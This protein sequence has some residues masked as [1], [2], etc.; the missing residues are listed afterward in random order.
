MPTDTEYVRFTISL[1][2][3]T[4]QSSAIHKLGRPITP[5]F[6]G[7]AE[8]EFWAVRSVDDPEPDI[9]RR[10]IVGMLVS[11]SDRDVFFFSNG[12]CVRICKCGV[13]DPAPL[14]ARQ[15]Q[16]GWRRHVRRTCDE[17][18]RGP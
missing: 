13:D 6:G 8:V 7:R 4:Q 10:T 14:L 3:S 11:L 16:R 5:S 17:H 9:T 1:K 15:R 12:R 2:R 18:G